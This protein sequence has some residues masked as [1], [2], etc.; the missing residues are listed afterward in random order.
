[1]ENRGKKS[2]LHLFHTLDGICG[3][4]ILYSY[5]L[6]SPSSFYGLMFLCVLIF[7]LFPC[8]LSSI[9]ICQNFYTKKFP[10][11]VHFVCFRHTANIR[12]RTVKHS[13]SSGKISTL[14]CLHL[15]FLPRLVLK[16]TVLL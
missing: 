8:F 12:N 10:S 14:C 4:D 11:F 13:S 7:T 5:C 2:T 1:M 15:C 3:T 9:P 16:S 6:S